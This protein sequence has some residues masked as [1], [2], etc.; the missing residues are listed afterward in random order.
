[1]AG[2][3]RRAKRGGFLSGLFGLINP[4][5]D[6]S[7]LIAVILTVI[8]QGS[9]PQEWWRWALF[10]LLNWIAVK[11]VIWL[12]V[13][14]AFSFV[15]L[16]RTGFWVMRTPRPAWRLP[17]A[18][19]AEEIIIGGR[20]PDMFASE[21]GQLHPGQLGVAMAAPYGGAFAPQISEEP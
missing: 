14:F 8:W 7:L 1:M 21:E 6:P 10:G 2:G 19:A 18:L 4:I 3:N 17:D 20:R 11:G 16:V 15:Y 9:T 5:R 12:L 13:N